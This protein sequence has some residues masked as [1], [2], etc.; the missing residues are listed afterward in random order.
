MANRK[1][2]I[3]RYF[4]IIGFLMLLS[5]P[6]YF[7][8]I[9]FKEYLYNNQKIGCI[10]SGYVYEDTCTYVTVGLENIDQANEFI[11]HYKFYSIDSITPRKF[12]FCDIP[13]NAHCCIKDS[14]LVNNVKLYKITYFMKNNLYYNNCYI[15][16]KSF[17]AKVASDDLIYKFEKKWGIDKYEGLKDW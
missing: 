10:R 13:F 1:S 4:I 6:L 5:Y 3:V 15:I 7:G 12:D 2:R 17:H 11:K 9:F 8:S 14:I 16:D